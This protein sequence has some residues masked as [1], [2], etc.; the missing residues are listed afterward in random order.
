MKSAVAAF[1]V[2][3]KADHA[4]WDCKSMYPKPEPIDLGLPDWLGGVT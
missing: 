2:A 1:D 4:K 3:A